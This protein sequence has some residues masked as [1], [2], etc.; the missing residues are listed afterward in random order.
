M[1]A[2]RNRISVALLLSGALFTVHV[3]PARSQPAPA[4]AAQADPASLVGQDVRIVTITGAVWPGRLADASGDG[5]TVQGSSG[6]FTISR[7]AVRSI[8]PLAAARVRQAMAT[9][10]VPVDGGELR[11]HGSNTVGAQMLPNL[12]EVYGQ[13][14][15]RTK[16][17]VTPGKVDEER[18]ITLSGDNPASSLNV[19]LHS[20]GTGTA[21]TSLAAGAADLGMASRPANDK[22]REAL[23][24]LGLGDPRSAAQEHVVGLDGVSVIVN[25]GNPVGALSLAQ[26]AAVF[27]GA[28]KDWSELGGRPG[29]INLYSLDAKSGTFDTFKD[30]ALH[31]KPLGAGAR[32]FESSTELSDEVAGDPGGIGFIGLAYIRQ[33]KPLTVA[34]SC[35][36]AVPTEAF[37]IRTEEYPLSRRLFLYTPAAPARLAT[38]FLTFVSSAEAQPAIAASGFVNLMPET[39]SMAYSEFRKRTAPDLLANPGDNVDPGRAQAIVQ[40]LRPL[41]SDGRRLSITFRYQADSTALDNRGESDINRLVAWSNDPANAGRGVVLVGYSSSVGSFTQN[42]NLSRERADAL[43]RRLQAAGLRVAATVGAGPVSPVA[44]NTDGRGQALNRR[45]EVWVR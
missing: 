3:A 39:A 31:G 15:R 12:L 42:V 35:G 30:L 29:P 36:L 19:E 27:T 44:C 18:R 24:S 7:S 1:R 20:H 23:K 26:I 14:S 38:D 34:Q 4:A 11:I 40:T 10:S 28:V 2:E 8:E 25:P 17:Q 21:F 41:F 6:A 5:L 43:A 33:A 13:A 32:T 16:V 22:E 45:V 37:N 9:A